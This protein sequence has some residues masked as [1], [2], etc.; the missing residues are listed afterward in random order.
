MTAAV[1]WA[2]PEGGSTIFELVW[3]FALTTDWWH[4]HWCVRAEGVDEGGPVV[5]GACR[6][7]QGVRGGSRAFGARIH[8]TCIVMEPRGMA[9]CVVA[10]C[11]CGARDWCDG[12]LGMAPH[13]GKGVNCIWTPAA[14]PAGPNALLL[15]LSTDSTI[16]VPH[17]V[18]TLRTACVL[19]SP[20][21]AGRRRGTPP[22]WC[23]TCRRA[24]SWQ[25]CPLRCPATRLQEVQ[26]PGILPRPH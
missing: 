11:M 25:P 17:W 8:A 12:P 6:Q 2:G 19:P 1:L 26:A 20:P 22:R 15:R 21:C 23:S 16:C 9:A 7:E 14:S 24:G 13:V 18:V 3:C 5:D 4:Q 10:V